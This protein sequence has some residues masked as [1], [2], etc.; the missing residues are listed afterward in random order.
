MGKAS[1]N[2]LS[3]VGRAPSATHEPDQPQNWPYG[4]VGVELTD[5]D[6]DECIE[7]TIHGVK[8][9]LHSSTAREL[10]NMLVAKIDEWNGTAKMA[11]FPGV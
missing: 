9:Y 5:P 3:R 4:H 2:K 1:R 11:G 7:V 10:S 6:E 8:H